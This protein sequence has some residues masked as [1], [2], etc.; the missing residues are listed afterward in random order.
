MDDA[1]Q[2]RLQYIIKEFSEIFATVFLTA[3]KD[4]LIESIKESVQPP[5]ED[6]RKLPDMPIP[7]DPL[8][9]GSVNK[10]CA[11]RKNWKVNHFVAMNEADNFRIDYFDK[12]GGSKKGSINGAGYKAKS[13]E[14][15][16]GI[17]IVPSDDSR[18]TYRLKF[19]TPEVRDEWFGVISNACKKAKAPVNPDKVLSK[20]FD[21]AYRALRWRYGYYG[22]YQIYYT[23]AEQLGQLCLQIVYR[24]LINDVIYNIPAGPARNFTVK[25][26]RKSVDA[27]VIGAIASAWSA[28]CEAVKPVRGPL[29]EAAKG[30]LTPL[31]EEE[32]KLKEAIAEKANEKVN[33]FL[34]DVGG[35]ICEPVLGVCVASIT[36]AYTSAF[37]GFATFMQQHIKDGGF[38]DDEKTTRTLQRC[39][40]ETEYWYNGP[41]SESY[42]ICWEMYTGKLKVLNNIFDG[43]DFSTYDL[44]YKTMDEIKSLTHRAV[45]AYATGLAEFKGKDRDLTGLLNDVLARYL[46]DS[47]LSMKVLLNG[48]LGDL[49][50]SP[51]ES[52][53]LTPA[54]LL[55]AP[56]QEMLD[57]IPVPGLSD[58][59]NLNTLTEEVVQRFVADGLDTL[60]SASFGKVGGA[61]DAEG[62]KLGITS[63]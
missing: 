13:I 57:S 1:K 47:K 41:L 55:V 21:S 56:L 40:W 3:Y 32:V 26:V 59:F 53:V 28:S 48:I 7:T 6:L 52:V 20:A 11:F 18:R 9:E 25:S 14:E 46:H 42:K 50:A 43:G 2:E 31:F 29:E 12:E 15:D 61:I 8:K 58:L 24:E 19:D 4:A 38:D 45:N 35:R 51:I 16:N 49:L 30:L 62:K 60:V 27:T 33:P 34:T 63:A 17:E 5:E 36:D 39:H 22:Y 23:E 37:K 54:L 44:Y 10:E